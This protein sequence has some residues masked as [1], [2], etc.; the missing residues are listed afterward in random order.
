M[1]GMRMDISVMGT[2]NY[3]ILTPTKGTVFMPVQGMSEPT[4]M[5]DDQLKSGQSQLD[6]QGSLVDYKEK[7]TS[8]ELVGNEKVDGEDCNN[9]KLTFKSGVVTNYYISAKTSFIVKTN[10]KRMIN[11]EE[12]EIATTYSNYKQNADG[13]WFPYTTTNMQGTTDFS[14]IDT[15][16]VIDESVFKQ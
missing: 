13:Y 1:V 9:L 12:T 5:P 2:E 3:Q 7:G 6:L 10:G 11:G 8:I 15:N 14:K 16:V 4:V